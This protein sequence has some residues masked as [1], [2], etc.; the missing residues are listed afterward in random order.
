MITS[1]RRVLVVGAG[2]VGRSVAYHLTLRNFEVSIIDAGPDP[3][4]TSRASLGVLTHFNGGDNPLSHFYRDGHDSFAELATRLHDETGVDIG[5][6]KP[7]GIDLIFTD[8]DEEQAEE[9]LR[10]NRER[11]CPV[12]R[13]DAQ[14][15]R[16]LE[17]QVSSRARGGV[18]FPGD[19]RVDPERLSEG[20][21]QAVRQRGGSVSFGEALEEFKEV[22]DDHVRVRTSRGERS[23]DFLVLAAGAWT[24]EIGERLGVTI[25]VRPIRGQHGRFGG[26]EQVRHILRHGGYHLLPVEEQIAVGTTV[27]EVGFDDG[28]TVEAAQR[29]AEVLDHALDLKTRIGE[30]RA[31]LRPKPKGGRPLIGPLT[32]YPQ[33]LAA[34]GHYK[35]GIL[36]GPLTGRVVAEW[37]ETGESLR[38]MSYFK[39]ER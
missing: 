15:L 31:G 29:F 21:L 14:G 35:N 5:W 6:R 1:H 18:Y 22:G 39:P 28:T 34:T 8:E 23:A 11:D 4:A 30:Q 36:M 13:I 37:I 33:I 26:G 19:H 9:S 10:F 27:E 12:E 16:R 38:D 32:D 20:L 3:S 25:P 24:R 17:P 2:V 7:G